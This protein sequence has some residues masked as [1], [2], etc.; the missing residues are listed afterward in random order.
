M[1]RYTKGSGS[2]AFRHASRRS[3]SSFYE[4]KLRSVWGNETLCRI[5]FRKSIRS[6]SFHSL[7]SLHR[8]LIIITTSKSLC[9]SCKKRPLVKP[10]HEIKVTWVLGYACNLSYQSTYQSSNP[11]PADER[12]PQSWVTKA[13]APNIV[14]R[15]ELRTETKEKPT[16]KIDP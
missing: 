16:R 5:W 12:N 3:S 13:C 14:D 9:I 2:L 4:L 11:Q 1:L 8:N 7:P 10:I 6:L 15:V